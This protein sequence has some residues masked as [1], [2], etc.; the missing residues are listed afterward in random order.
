MKALFNKYWAIPIRQITANGEPS[1]KAFSPAALRSSQVDDRC[2][3]NLRIGDLVQFNNYGSLN[4]NPLRVSW[5]AD[6][7]SRVTHRQ[8]GAGQHTAA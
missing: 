1:A 5:A 4:Q 8:C 7:T 2:L 6:Q 3:E